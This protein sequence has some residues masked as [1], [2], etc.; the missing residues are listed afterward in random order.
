MDT[1]LLLHP[2][3]EPGAAPPPRAAP[4]PPARTPAAAKTTARRR[5]DSLPCRPWLEHLH[6]H[7]AVARSGEDPE[8]VHQVRVAAGRLDVWLQM[9]RMHVL[10][11]DLRWL[12]RQAAAVRDL[13]VLLLSGPPE[14]FMVWLLQHYGEERRRLVASLE[15]PRLDGLLAA[16][17]G[18]PPLPRASAAAFLPR[19]GARVLR[20]GRRALRQRDAV[21]A[22]HGLR[23][24]LRRLRY[25]LEWLGKRPR[26][27]KKL[28]EAMGDFNDTAVA[29]RLLRS[30]PEAAALAAY[31]QA[32]AQELERR[33]AAALRAWTHTVPFLE[34]SVHAWNCS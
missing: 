13:D 10:R 4:A 25:A 17:A 30:C 21:E 1:P 29:V 27:L 24:A 9:G 11:D 33:R 31:E 6:A 3:A 32:L 34:E 2:R 22:M 5:G 16:L 28:Q 7:L 18:L 20:R 8:G 14:P 23:R 19:I 15:E 12:R 26:E